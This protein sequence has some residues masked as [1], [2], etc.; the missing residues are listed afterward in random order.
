MKKYIG[1]IDQGT[2]STRFIILDKKSNV[3]ASHQLEHKQHYPQ[4]GW[5][6]HDAVEIWANT[7]KVILETLKKSM[8]SETEL[9][10]IGITNQRETCVVWNRN[11]GKPYYHAIVWQDT[12]TESICHSLNNHSKQIEQKTG[13]PIATYFSASKLKWLLGNVEGLRIDAEAGEAIFGNIDTWLLWNLTG[14]HK[15]DVTNAS[16]TMLMNLQTLNWD[17]ELLQLFDIPA[18]MLPQICSSSEVYGNTQNCFEKSIPV[19]GILGD[20]QAALFGQTC[21]SKGEAKNT[22]GTGCFM[23]LNTGSEIV[24]STHGLLTTVAY[25]LGNSKPVYA[26][27][28]SIAIAGSLV[29]WIRDNF[30]FIKESAEINELAEKVSDNGG[31]Y[32]VPAFS[33]LFAPHWDATARGA[34]VGITHYVNQS[35][36][37]RAVLEATAFQSSDVFE[38]MMKDAKVELKTLKV[39]GGMT[40]SDLLM[41]FQA[42]ILD[43]DVIKPKITETTALGAAFVA[44]LAIGFWQNKDELRQYWQVD[45]IYK[46]NIDTAKRDNLKNNWNK[47]IS[48]SSGWQEN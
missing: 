40:A 26:L 43:V 18:Q 9:A 7:K 48:K 13:L 47:A 35:H 41:Q 45:K 30:G 33:G 32:F 12:R 24:H 46:P 21:F 6:E 15:T 36:I 10:A 42:D 8:I 3:V 5:V 4:P 19:C 38:A 16:R 27:E 1:A 25:K 2:T 20:Q 28:G 11:S 39:D 14:E 17:E 22:Y 37:A 23:L 31:V 29:Q 34:I 44:G